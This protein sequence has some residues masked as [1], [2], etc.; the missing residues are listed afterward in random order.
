MVSQWKGPEQVEHHNFCSLI[1]LKAWF[2]A[3]IPQVPDVFLRA[4][5]KRKE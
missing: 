4:F 5:E 3:Q 2:D 1:C